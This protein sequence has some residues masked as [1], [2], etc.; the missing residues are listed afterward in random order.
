[1]G[2]NTHVIEVHEART[3]NSPKTALDDLK[4]PSPIWEMLR[5]Q[6]TY[7]SDFS[8]FTVLLF[9][10]SS[11]LLDW[12]V[13]PLVCFYLLHIVFRQERWRKLEH[14]L[15]DF[16]VLVPHMLMWDVEGSGVPWKSVDGSFYLFRS[17]LQRTGLVRASTILFG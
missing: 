15:L 12:F 8:G 10:W 9:C 1:M 16:F 17:N 7:F 2:S 14:C 13:F 3:A 5:W 6:T 4:Q 11:T